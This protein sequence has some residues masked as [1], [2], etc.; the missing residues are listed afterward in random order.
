L[1]AL[2][3]LGGASPVHAMS[4]SGRASTS[5]RLGAAMVDGRP[6]KGQ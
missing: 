6:Q 5:I 2:G 4:V 1:V 3:S